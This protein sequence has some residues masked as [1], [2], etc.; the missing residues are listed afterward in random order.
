MRINILNKE[1]RYMRQG[2]VDL[3]EVGLVP[4]SNL[5]IVKDNIVA[6]G[7]QTNHHHQF[8]TGQVQVFREKDSPAMAMASYVVVKEGS[9]TLEH[10]EHLPLQVPEGKWMVHHEEQFNPFKG[11]MEKVMD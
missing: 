2:D 1:L 9:A 7:E 11:E 8:K 3:I 10:Q 5:E 4:T 6:Y